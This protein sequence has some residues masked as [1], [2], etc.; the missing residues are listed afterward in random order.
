MATH[1]SFG[2]WGLDMS[3][4]ILT[5]FQGVLDILTQF[6]PPNICNCGSHWQMYLFYFL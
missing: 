3:V 6:D 4:F 5:L 1:Y 2:I